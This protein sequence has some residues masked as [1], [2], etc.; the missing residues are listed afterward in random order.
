MQI[1][2]C[3]PAYAEEIQI[4]ETTIEATE[5]GYRLATSFGLELNQELEDALLRGIPLYFTIEVEVSR[6]R[7]YWFDETTLSASQTFKISYNVLTRQYRVSTSTNG[8]L[9]RTFNSLGEALAAIRNPARWLI[10]DHGTFKSG[11]I[12]QVSVRMGLD[13]TQLPKPFQVN[14]L[15][16]SEWRISSGW[17]QFNFKVENR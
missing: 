14:A 1:I 17:K 16:S 8:G 10:A 7:R 2:V 12:Y 5:E 3:F 11:E 4:K 6:P 13:V 15:N 9:S